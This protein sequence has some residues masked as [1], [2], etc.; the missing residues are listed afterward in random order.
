M[1][2]KSI[3][4]PVIFLNLETPSRVSQK[5]MH[6]RFKANVP[7]EACTKLGGLFR[8]EKSGWKGLYKALQLS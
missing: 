5:A 3:E 7:S 4:Y 8:N 1:V 6:E 2:Y